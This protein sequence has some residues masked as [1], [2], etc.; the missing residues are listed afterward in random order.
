MKDTLLRLFTIFIA[1]A[2]FVSLQ[3][4]AAPREYQVDLEPF[5]E[6][7]ADFKRYSQGRE[8]STGTAHP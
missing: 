7:S 8:V 1:A 4:S 6:F 3:A 5:K 2:S